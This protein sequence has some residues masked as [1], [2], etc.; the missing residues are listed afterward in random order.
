MERKIDL[1]LNNPQN[2]ILYKYHQT[3]I[4]QGRLKKQFK[5]NISVPYKSLTQ[6]R[7]KEKFKMHSLVP[8]N[9]LTR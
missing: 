4:A 7:L 5:T 2:H 3:C 8:Y 9:L 1:L 6:G